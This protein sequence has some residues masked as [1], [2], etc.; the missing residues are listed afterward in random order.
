MTEIYLDQ[1]ATSK[2]RQEVIDAIMPYLTSYWH[3]PSGLYNAG[4]KVRYD[5]ESVRNEI[6][7][8]INARPDE[9]YFTSG[10]TEANNWAIRGFD[11]AC[12]GYKVDIITTPIEHSSI[13]KAIGNSNIRSN[14]KFFD[15]D[16]YGIVDLNSF[17]KNNDSW[18]FLA[19]V[20]AANN[21]I[22]SVN[23]LK[24]ISKIVH[25]NNG[26]F[27]TDATQMLP[28]IKIDVDEMG[29]DMLSASAQKLGGLKGAGFLYIRNSVKNK[30]NP[31]IYG[32]QERGM[33]GGTENVIGIIAMGE[34]IKHINYDCSNLINM[35]DVFIT[36]L[37]NIGCK[38]L[39]SRERRLP[40][41]I[42]IMLPEGCGGE[43]ML[44]LCDISMIEIST[45]SACNSHSKDSSHVLKAIGL[46]D[47]EAA[48]VIRISLPY[49][50]K[51]AE[52]QI[53]LDEIKKGIKLLGGNMDY[54]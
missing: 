41:N 28:Y 27:H 21:E 23:D 20:I 31:L 44:Y 16:S 9:I 32:E 48:R 2:P 7:S 26:I 1:A 24:S 8:L 50:L 47:E 53:A 6:A 13:M 30:I 42:S 46:S 3:N 36:E 10:A 11:D 18:V 17:D 49:D 29:I 19:S 52:A 43:E 5:I 34:A 25:S 54:V 45:G 22:G 51:P 39:G 40:N 35:R 4:A 14:I 12:G 38:L 15:V 37:E 33:R